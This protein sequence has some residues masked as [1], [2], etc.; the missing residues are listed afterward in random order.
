MRRDV[1]VLQTLEDLVDSVE[2][3][4]LVLYSLSWKLLSLPAYFQCISEFFICQPE[5]IRYPG[6]I[7]FKV[8]AAKIGSSKRPKWSSLGVRVDTCKSR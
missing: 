2:S 1:M 6:P 4:S 5:G 3:L 7:V 8:V